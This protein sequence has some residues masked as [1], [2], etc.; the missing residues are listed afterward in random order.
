MTSSPLLVKNI[1]I[2]VYINV[3]KDIYDAFI[4]SWKVIQFEKCNNAAI[5][6]EKRKKFIVLWGVIDTKIL[7]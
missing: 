3:F 6:N 4:S 2:F 1:Q 7:S 5:K